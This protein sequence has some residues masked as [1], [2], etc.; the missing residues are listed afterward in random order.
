MKT[1]CSNR[2]V[3]NLHMPSF[4]LNICPSLKVD[5]DNDALGFLLSPTPLSRAQ[6]YIHVCMYFTTN[7]PR[8]EALLAYDLS[9][10]TLWM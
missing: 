1:H 6:M 4:E 9:N 2:Y 8:F 5:F 7:V 3:N 10:F